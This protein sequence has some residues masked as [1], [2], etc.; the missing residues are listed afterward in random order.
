LLLKRVLSHDGLNDL[1]LVDSVLTWSW[2]NEVG[3]HFFRGIEFRAFR[4]PGCLGGA[5]PVRI[6]SLWSI[7]LKVGSSRFVSDKRTAYNGLTLLNH[8]D[9]CAGEWNGLVA[10]G[11][12]VHNLALSCANSKI[13]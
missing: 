2:R 13:V 6:V 1:D 10:P 9:E 8:V 7:H 4:S 12:G 3:F 5:E 11:S